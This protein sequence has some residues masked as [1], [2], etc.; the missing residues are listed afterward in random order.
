MMTLDELI[1]RL[2]KLSAEGHG[3]LPVIGIGA[4]EY[5]WGHSPVEDVVVRQTVTRNYRDDGTF[6]DWTEVKGI[7]SDLFVEI[8]SR[9][10]E[11]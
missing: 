5:D 11:D 4:G 1:A 2:E 10:I 7:D 8:V 6:Y 3:Q 9:D